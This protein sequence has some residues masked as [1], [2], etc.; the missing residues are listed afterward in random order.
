MSQYE[1]DA[2]DVAD[3]LGKEYMESLFVCLYKYYADV[4][5]FIDFRLTAILC[6]MS[7]EDYD[8]VRKCI[9]KYNSRTTYDTVKY[10]PG[11][12]IT[13]EQID[14][15]LEDPELLVY[16]ERMQST[17]YVEQFIEMLKAN[18]IKNRL[19]G[20]E[21]VLEVYIGCNQQPVPH[22]HSK[23]LMEMILEQI[24]TAKVYITREGVDEYPQAR[25]VGLQHFSVYNLERIL[26]TPA[27]NAHVES[28]LFAGRGLVSPTRITRT[29]PGMTN[30]E[31]FEYTSE[32]LNMFFDFNYITPKVRHG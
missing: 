23:Q 17:T 6:L 26:N 29:N 22:I 11:L 10:F 32:L 20:H 8:I 1:Q 2:A 18:D 16:T 28:G 5:L 7:A 30:K 4:E 27:F 9:G 14:D 24:P 25:M 3:M 19:S 12:S 31:V 15:F 21:E 13:E